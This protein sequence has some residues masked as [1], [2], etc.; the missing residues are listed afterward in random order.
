MKS[1]FSEPKAVQM[2]QADSTFIVKS[3][4]HFFW[5]NMNREKITSAEFPFIPI[6]PLIVHYLFY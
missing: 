6:N 5:V 2:Q 3:K 4:V 1:T